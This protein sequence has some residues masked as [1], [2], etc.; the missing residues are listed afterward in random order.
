MLAI[1]R[2]NIWSFF[3][4]FEELW[5]YTLYGLCLKGLWLF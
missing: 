4:E 1:V 2:G 3:L 5:E